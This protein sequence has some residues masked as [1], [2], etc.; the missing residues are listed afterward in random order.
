MLVNVSAPSSPLPASVSV[1]EVKPVTR[2]P[3]SAVNT[4]RVAGAA[5]E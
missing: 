3:E 5:P 4:D 1:T 2:P